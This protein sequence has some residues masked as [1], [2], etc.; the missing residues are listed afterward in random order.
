VY[1]YIVNLF[2]DR[3]SISI[4]QP[5]KLGFKKCKS[6]D[7]NTTNAMFVRKNYMASPKRYKEYMLRVINHYPMKTGGVAPQLHALT[8]ALDGGDGS[9]L[10]HSCFT[11]RIRA[12]INHWMEYCSEEKNTYPCQK[13]NPVSR[14][15]TPSLVATSGT[16]PTEFA[17]PVLWLPQ[18]EIHVC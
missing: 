12:P 13:M 10:R 5:Q 11:T 3:V 4:I 8:P 16:V 9:T 2:S 17:I 14:S 18:R 15:C 6:K 1:I 7:N